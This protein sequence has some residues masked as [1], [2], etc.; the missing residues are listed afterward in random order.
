VQADFT[1]WRDRRGDRQ[2]AEIV[3]ERHTTAPAADKPG[4]VERPQR[5][6]ADRQRSEEVIG[7]RLRGRRQQ[8]DDVPRLVVERH[9]PGQDRV[10]DRCR[11]VGAVVVEHLGDVER[12]AAGEPL[13][14]RRVERPTTDEVVDRGHGQR[15]EPDRRRIGRAGDVAEQPAHRVVG[16]DLLVA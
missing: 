2:A 15:T 4:T 14:A 8:M 12:V 10:A 7:D 1:A 5:W 3:A 6:H 9:G 11:Q 13:D 16:G